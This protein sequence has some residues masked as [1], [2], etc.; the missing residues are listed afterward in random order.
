[1]NT[2]E[3]YCTNYSVIIQADT[4]KKAVEKFEKENPKEEIIIVKNVLYKD[5]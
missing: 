2:Y 3:I 4:V 1:M 5:V